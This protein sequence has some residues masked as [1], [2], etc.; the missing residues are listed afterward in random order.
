M[1]KYLFSLSILLFLLP[2][3]GASFLLFKELN[4]DIIITEREISGAY[5]H[6]ELFKLLR[7]AQ[8]YRGAMIL[9]RDKSVIDRYKNEIAIAIAKVDSLQNITN[10]FG[11][12]DAWKD[13]R[14]KIL[15]VQEQGDVYGFLEEFEM[16]SSSIHALSEYMRSMT[17]HSSLI[18][19]SEIQSYYFIDFIT[20]TV[21]ELVEHLGYI[22]SKV[23]KNLVYGVDNKDLKLL[24]SE[25][26]GV[27]ES[28]YNQYRFVRSLT[29]VM[30]KEYGESY[31]LLKKNNNQV[32]DDALVM[33]RGMV[34][35][36]ASEQNPQV[37]FDSM[38]S[39]IIAFDLTY[40]AYSE[41]LRSILI[42]RLEANKKLR[43]Q[44][45]TALATML[46]TTL[47]IFIFAQR[48]RLKL[49]FDKAKRL[50]SYIVESSDDAIL[51]RHLDGTIMSW[52]GGAERLFGYKASEVIGKNI[53][54]IIPD[55][56]L[57]AEEEI[58]KKIIGGES[59]THLEMVRKHKN[60]HLVNISVSTSS[61]R[62]E[63]GGII[64]VSKVARDITEIKKIT[65]D[66]SNTMVGI[67]KAMAVAEFSMDGTILNAN[68]IYLK[69]MEYNLDELKDRNHN[70]LVEQSYAKSS[71]YKDFWK[72]LANNE[73][74]EGEF[75]Q[76]TKIGTKVCLQGVF[77]LLLGIDKKP[78]KVVQFASDVTER[79]R[80]QERISRFANE[81]EKKNAELEVAREQSE[82]ANKMKS[83]FL[84]TMSHE[85]RTPMNGIIGMTELL[86]ESQL[87]A[88]Q[89]DYSRTVMHSAEALLSIIND[90]LDFSKIESGKLELEEMPFDLQVMLD[91]TTDLLAVKAREKAIEFI[92]RYVPETTRDLIGD[93]SR[94]RQI[95]TNLVGNAIK[96]TERGRVLLKVEELG[97]SQHDSNKAIIKVS[98]E[99]TGIGIPKNAQTK[100]FQKFTQADSSTTRKYGGT[101]LGLAICRQMV[102]MMGGEINLESTEGVGSVFSFT[103]VLPRHDQVLIQENIINTVHLAGT[104]I[105]IVDDLVDN[106]TIVKERLEA[107][108]MKCIAC[109]DSM[110][111]MDILY[112]QKEIGEPVDIALID[113]LMPYLNGENLAKQIKAHDSLVKDIAIILLT[114]S[115]GHGFSKRFVS[116]GISAYLSKPIHS[117]QLIETISKVWQ[118]WKKGEREGLLVAEN[119]RTR[120]QNDDNARF[121]GARILMAEDNRVNQG[122]AT[123]MLES[124]GVT[125]QIAANGREAIDKIKEQQFDLVL[126]DCQ[127][128]IMD[129]FEASCTIT[130]MKNKKEVAD[131]P[132]IALTAN[133]MKGD[134]ERCLEAGMNDYI[135]KP[136]RKTDL[137][138]SLSRWLPERLVSHPEESERHIIES[139][140]DILF[141]NA[142]VLL[143]EDNRINRE[144]VVELLESMGCFVTIAENGLVATKRIQSGE[145]DVVLMDCQMPEMDGYEATR[146][147]RRMIDDGDIKRVP[148]IALTADAMKGDREKCLNAGMD[149]YIAKPVKKQQLGEMLLKWVSANRQHVQS[150]NIHKNDNKHMPR[151]LVVDDNAVHQAYIS[152]MLT[153]MGYESI[154]VSNGKVAI[155]N[156]QDDA[157]DL[158]LMDCE[159]PVMNGWE[160][161]KKISDM[162]KKGEISD[163]PVIALTANQQEGDSERCFISG[164][165]DYIAKTIWKPKWQPNIE[166]ILRKWLSRNNA[167]SSL[168]MMLDRRTL[169]ETRTLMCGKFSMFVKMFLEDAHNH[170]EEIINIAEENKI[171]EDIILPVHSLKSTSRQVGAF[172]LSNLAKH[173]EEKA[174]QVVKFSGNSSS[175]QSDIERLKEIYGELRILLLNEIGE[176]A[177][178]GFHAESIIKAKAS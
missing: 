29:E 40:N 38:S 131:I 33:L 48:A 130:A 177:D 168:D 75:E 71:E 156:L 158:V 91:E 111:A 94:I 95:V 104:R 126:M 67:N 53:K 146:V 59:F 9:G 49:E 138:Q 21:P 78:Y 10:E 167:S 170:I 58:I 123:E 85:I 105:L 155:E 154:V 62:D 27:L 47:G 82:H 141:D 17:G 5:Y 41:H 98:V 92:F 6:S 171:A 174:A 118:A 72:A 43:F 3:C 54:I 107:L 87:N 30:L 4:K 176:I 37:F 36:K 22:R 153:N 12:Q 56:Y 76:I 115:A 84:A 114:S 11:L 16:H 112:R 89:Q 120:V 128:P 172:H 133:A 46:V 101:G 7:A 148:I 73:Y 102:E 108:G 28:L 132:I 79:K 160:A 164:F 35:G 44:I 90:I 151:I 140:S 152:E 110:Q 96:F 14:A 137:I 175:L 63:K 60:G 139:D 109:E 32:F 77:F 178:D 165:D 121:D 125:V 129:G 116:A 143:V 19:D 124:L 150:G 23:T 145:F 39:A 25:Q 149:D 86:L 65:A 173:I 64:G 117:R 68:N 34:D 100:L 159:M 24:V 15:A 61:I 99:D 93:P 50:L 42:Q 45:I 144:F 57:S 169:E 1:R 97:S 31:N 161:A 2:F 147:M 162:R 18:L 51:S 136:M 166:K 134:R 119:V 66:L 13:V 88:R 70:I 113:Y 55:E 20:I 122:F 106:I 69:I 81:M 8:E 83:E 157:F 74:Q 142:Q 80:T 127:M 26:V 135:A 52:N 163:I 103:M